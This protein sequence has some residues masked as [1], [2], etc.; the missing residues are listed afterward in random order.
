MK[1]VTAITAL[2][3]RAN[4]SCV[5]GQATRHCGR[6][7]EMIGMLRNPECCVPFPKSVQ[8][9]GRFLEGAFAPS[10]GPRVD[11][12]LPITIM[13]RPGDQLRSPARLFEGVIA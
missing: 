8:S 3:W 12:L 2:A 1:Q 11:K 7:S 5:R 6:E 13:L 9:N 4:E 10:P